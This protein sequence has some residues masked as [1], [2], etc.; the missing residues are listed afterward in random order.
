MNIINHQHYP[1]GVNSNPSR[2][3]NSLADLIKNNFNAASSSS[4]TNSQQI[5][6]ETWL[7]KLIDSSHLITFCISIS[8]IIYGSF[9]SLNIDVRKAASIS[10]ESID[11]KNEQDSENEQQNFQQSIQTIDSTQALIIPIAASVS[12]LLMF[13]FF[14]SIQTAFLIC[15]SSNSFLILD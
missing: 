1:I 14:D 5:T 12:L 2:K 13:F 10:D 6:Q 7:H 3:P 11:N 8:V 4:F 15:T 9:R